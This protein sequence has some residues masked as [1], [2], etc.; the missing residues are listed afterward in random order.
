[1]PVRVRPS[2]PKKTTCLTSRFFWYLLFLHKYDII[3]CKYNNIIISKFLFLGGRLTMKEKKFLL[4]A[5]IT[6]LIFLGI[7]YFFKIPRT[8]II[9]TFIGT[10]LLVVLILQGFTFYLKY[11]TTQYYKVL[12]KDFELVVNLHKHK[13][14]S[15][16]ID[17]NKARLSEY[18]QAFEFHCN[19]FINDLEKEETKKMVKFTKKQDQ[20]LQKMLKKAKEMTEKIY[21]PDYSI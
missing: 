4:E 10:L 15:Y 1:M 17:D 16:F 18:S 14:K 6:I 19:K 20:V 7:T 13:Y 11:L 3:L 5:F 9:Y 12:T 8:V 2:A 21:I